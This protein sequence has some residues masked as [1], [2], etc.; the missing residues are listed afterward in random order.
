MTR[1]FIVMCSELG[2][3]YIECMKISRK[4]VH[5]ITIEEWADYDKEK[6]LDAQRLLTDNEKGVLVSYLKSC[7]GILRR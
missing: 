7:E 4:L 6:F 1:S 2:I 5:G 3:S